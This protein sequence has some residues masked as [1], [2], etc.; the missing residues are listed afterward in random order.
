M[1]IKVALV[2]DDKVIRLELEAIIRSAEKMEL[3][4]SFSNAEDFEKQFMKSEV[5]VVLQDINLPG[6]SGIESVLKCKMM[7]PAV[8]F[9]MCTVFENNENIFE[10][11]CAG[12]TGYI[13]KNTP[14]H[15]LLDAIRDVYN[16]GSPMSPNIARLLV[17]SFPQMRNNAGKISAAYE[18]LSDREKQIVEL[19]AKGFQYKEIGEQLFIT[20]ETVR[21]HIRRIYEKLHVNTRTEA[22]NKV[23]PRH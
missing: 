14:P 17:T 2:E 1:L 9:I 11:L 4:G 20:T 5:N 21:T 13:V 8:Q 10:S 15:K 22:L 6:K 12:A 23:F 18:L 3:A 19:L 7:N 16:G